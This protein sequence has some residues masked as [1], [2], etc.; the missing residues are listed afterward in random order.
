M[1]DNNFVVNNGEIT[2]TPRANS[3]LIRSRVLLGLVALV[4]IVTGTMIASPNA[5]ADANSAYQ[6]RKMAQGDA[7]MAVCAVFDV[8]GVTDASILKI[9]DA[10]KSAGH[11]NGI[12]FENHDVSRFIID[13]VKYNCPEHVSA[14][15][16]SVSA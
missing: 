9:S 14:T 11:N 13:A 6:A 2:Q 16:P 8:V 4:A 12:E 5:H 1:N 15:K 10:M 7:G 3:Q